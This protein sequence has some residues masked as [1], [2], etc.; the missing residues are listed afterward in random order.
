VEGAA[1]PTPPSPEPRPPLV[2]R[3]ALRAAVADA[4]AAAR[5]GGAPPAL[6][7]VGDPGI[8]KTRLLDLVGDE[9]GAAG[10]TVLRGRAFEA[11]TVRPYGPWIDAL[12]AGTLPADVEPV[13]D[14]APL[15][16][17]LAGPAT[18]QAAGDRGRLHDAA[19]TLLERWSTRAGPLAIVLD[20]LQ[21]L[22][23]ASASLLHF[24]TR[25]RFGGRILIACAA[26]AGELGDSPAARRVV[27]AL[28]R[29]RRMIPH[30]VEP[31]GAAE[32]AEIV[33]AIS[34]GADAAA[35]F[36][37]SEGNP[38]FAIEIARAG[39]AGAET[40]DEPL[41]HLLY[42][43]LERL[44]EP[45]RELLP[46][47]AALGRS[48]DPEVL[49]IARGRAVAELVE[50][51]D[52]L[53][54]YGIIRDASGTSCD[55]SHDLLR[56]AAYRRLSPARRRLVHLQIA[57]G[58]RAARGGDDAYAGTIAH[59]AMLAGDALLAAE[60]ALAGAQRC[61]RVF[62][63]TE[64]AE[65]AN[66]GLQL[67]HRIERI[68]RIRLQIALS[69]V[70]V[71]AGRVGRSASDLEADLSR[72][73]VEAQEAGLHGEAAQGLRARSFL[74]YTGERFEAA[75]ESS[76]RAAEETRR[77][78]ATLRGQELAVSAR[79]LM[80][81][82][83]EVPRAQAMIGEAREV[84]GAEAERVP[85]VA[86]A[87]ALLARYTG[88]RATAA[89]EFEAAIEGFAR[90]GA[91]WERFQAMAQ[92]VMLNLEQ[93]R[94]DEARSRCGPLAEVAG[95]M[96]EGSE[97]AVAAA[98]AAITARAGARSGDPAPLEEAIRG[99]AAADTKA[100]LAYV[101]NAAAAQDLAAG[102]LAGAAE[103][104]RAALAAAVV[105]GRRSEIAVARSL[106]GRAALAR[107]DAAEAKG[108]LD[109]LDDD[110]RRALGLSRRAAAAADT[111]AAELAA[112]AARAPGRTS[113]PRSP[114][115]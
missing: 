7:F 21:W 81:L 42:E 100:M 55:F 99:L 68:S 79:C 101:L 85:A 103:R 70:L 80:L 40:R 35:A 94:P 72:A 110:R 114:R 107:G 73:I 87:A 112:A 15:L 102:D 34:P 60:S 59:H 4:V 47:A 36:A 6:L 30:R 13:P 29:E 56:Q 58:L 41:E 1:K 105:V 17:A 96:S 22:D 88:D 18:A 5:A 77:T 31:L 32:T 63:Y 76:L 61:L 65:L 52:H 44:S 84:L 57:R 10:G 14:L 89:R 62:A 24:V 86:W 111:L 25:G 8:G 83:N 9:V 48:F 49:A 98:L 50:P 104:A 38:L 93:G 3:S 106:L 113:G 64:A 69:A 67:M 46:W 66:R 51:L 115:S 43:R 2:G 26:R 53:E 92:M 54:R 28:E 11:E 39:A 71:E 78:D 108:H 19:G 91:H 82:E 95:K 33:R 90:A 16:P 20:D 109:A 97:P 75:R 27:R 37:A 74:Y 12:S 23:E 45:A